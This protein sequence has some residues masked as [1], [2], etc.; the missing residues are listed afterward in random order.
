MKKSK[1]DLVLIVTT[2]NDGSTID[3]WR[4]RMKKLG[5]QL[6]EIMTTEAWERQNAA[7]T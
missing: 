4:K 1:K 2:L 6:E 5:M 7:Q 3:E